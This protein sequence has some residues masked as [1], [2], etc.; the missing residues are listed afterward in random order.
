MSCITLDVDLQLRPAVSE[1]NAEEH[2]ES[3]TPAQQFCQSP[4]V[5][6]QGKILGIESDWEPFKN[7][8]VSKTLAYKSTLMEE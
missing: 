4:W 6:D 8:A 7:H 2:K 5:R 3:L 1:D